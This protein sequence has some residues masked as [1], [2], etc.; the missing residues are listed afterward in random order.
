M[1][2]QALVDH[3]PGARRYAFSDAIASYCRVR[4]GMTTRDPRLLQQVGLEMRHSSNPFVWLDALYWR[5]DEERPSLAI[6]TGVRFPDETS[7]IRQCGGMIWRIDRFT[8]AGQPFIATDRDPNHETE[9]ALD[10]FEFDVVLR[11]IS[12]EAASF[13]ESVISTY[14]RCVGGER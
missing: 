6:I 1:A 14:A 8:P 13:K 10:H 9:T 12:G 7:M 11:N 4:H 5:I 2:A 3:I